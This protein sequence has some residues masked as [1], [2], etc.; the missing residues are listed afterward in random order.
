MVGYVKM[1]SFKLQ[2]TCVF[3]SSSR[4][5]LSI[6][7]CHSSKDFFSDEFLYLPYLIHGIGLVHPMLK[8]PDAVRSDLLNEATCIRI[9]ENAENVS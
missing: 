4:F 9:K 3:T 6:T 7:T 1:M 8:I 5:P 2:L